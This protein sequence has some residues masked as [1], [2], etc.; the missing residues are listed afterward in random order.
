MMTKLTKRLVDGAEPRAAYF[1]WCGELTGF[2]LRVHPSGKKVYYTDYRNRDGARKRMAIGPHGKITTEEARKLALQI[3]GSVV[4]GDDPATERIT[5]RR[6]L[7]VSELCTNYMAT[8]EQGLIFGKQRQPKKPSTIAQDRAR[9]ARHIVPLLGRK[10]VCELTRADVSKFIRDVS[11]GKTAIVE[12]TLRLRGKAIVRGGA[13]TAARAVGFLGAI[14]SFAVSEGVLEHNPAH[15]VPRQADRRRTRRLTPDEYQ[16]L[17]ATLREAESCGETWQ[18]I[19]G[20]RLLALTGCRLGEIVQLKWSEIDAASGCFRLEDTK[21]GSS[22]RPIGRRV[23]DLLATVPQAAGC[24]YVL[25]AV[26]Q[27]GR[28]LGGLPKGCKRLA[29]RAG[30]EGVTPHTLRHSFASVA[31]DLGFTE[32]T[33][34]AML[35]H[36]AGSVTSRYVHHLDCVLVAA[37]DRVTERIEGFLEYEIPRDDTDTLVATIFRE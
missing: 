25:P 32:S 11:S 27:S 28:P 35:G 12:K 2:G 7:T 20:T 16:A 24:P 9:I 23:F 21:E 10:L 17:G 8:A 5:R 36:A 37:A 30:L 22:I 26:Q 15:G 19:M 29:A 3:L 34:A 33:I 13:G 1:L 6:S 18:V 4:K 31:G 14:L